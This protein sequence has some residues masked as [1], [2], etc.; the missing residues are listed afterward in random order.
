[1]DQ[2][3][4]EVAKLHAE[5]KKIIA[6]ALK[7]C[8]HP[9]LKPEDHEGNATAILARLAH[10]NILV[11]KY[12]PEQE[13]MSETIIW[14]DASK[15]KPDDDRDVLGMFYGI[16]AMVYWDAE[17]NTFRFTQEGK[18]TDG[19]KYWTEVPSGPQ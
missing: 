7:E 5:A 9:S 6:T 1:M 16:V 12:E 8:S 11:E 3:L 19:I 18:P 15:A 2:G 10:A 17:A 14:I 4:L 13:K